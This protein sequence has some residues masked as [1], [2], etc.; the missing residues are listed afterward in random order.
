M[1]LA[2]ILASLLS[3]WRY[4]KTPKPLHY[5]LKK[6]SN[7]LLFLHTPISPFHP[8]HISIHALFRNTL[9]CVLI[10]KYSTPFIYLYIQA[11]RKKIKTALPFSI[12]SVLV[13]FLFSLIV[14]EL[15]KHW[16]I[17]VKRN[18]ILSLRNNSLRIIRQKETNTEILHDY[19]SFIAVFKGS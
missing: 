2:I 8:P 16:I 10:R 3:L 18:S 4:T 5:A 9:N 12:A 15:I 13:E 17:N 19:I 6:I 11:V 14:I 1:L 7:K